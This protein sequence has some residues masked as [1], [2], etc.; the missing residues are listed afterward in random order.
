MCR[1]RVLTCDSS[2]LRFFLG[3]SPG[4]TGRPR[5][6]DFGFSPV[7]VW[8]RF[9]GIGLSPFDMRLRLAGLG[10]FKKNCQRVQGVPIFCLPLPTC[11]LRTATLLALDP[12]GQTVTKSKAYL[13]RRQANADRSEAR[14]M[15]KF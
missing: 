4:A 2:V 10:F 14:V 5:L 7:A 3:F 15:Y 1:V 8:R 6:R 11:P 9:G 12:F 13:D